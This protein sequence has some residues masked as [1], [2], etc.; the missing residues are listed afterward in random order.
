MSQPQNV[1]VTGANG[2]IGSKLCWDL[3]AAGHRVRGSVRR[4]PAR[5]GVDCQVMESGNIDGTTD[6]QRALTGIDSVVHCAARVHLGKSASPEE[7]EKCRRVNAEGTLA[8]AQQAAAAGAKRFIFL[9]T[10]GVP[11][12][13][14]AGEGE[15]AT[16]Y[17][18]SKGEA[19]AA[20]QELA[21]DYPS[22]SMVILRPPLVYGPGAPGNFAKLCEVIDR[23]W[24]LP[25]ASIQNRRSFLYLDN[26]TDLVV[27]CLTH[28]GAGGGTFEPSDGAA[29][30]TPAFIRELSEA[31]ETPVRLFPCP[32]PILAVLLRLAG[33]ERMAESLLG[34]RECDSSLLKERLGWS[35][36]FST[37]AGLRRTF[38]KAA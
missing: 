27:S 19:E 3:L 16:P 13:L 25:C 35:P 34:S 17:Q 26:L 37:R 24:P 4:L 30:T 2:F 32:P 7:L 28:E 15:G 38:G 14:D 31:K 23:G 1:L 29:L 10:L 22:L 33:R 6:W 9:S 21:A 36:K 5:I 18:I 11:S 20:L 8:L 12:T